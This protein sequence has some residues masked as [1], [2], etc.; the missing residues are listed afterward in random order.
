M[1]LKLSSITSITLNFFSGYHTV[2][3][4]SE[5]CQTSNMD[6]FGKTVNGFKPLTIFPKRST[7]DV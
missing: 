2:E 1:Y 3:E 6:R 7:L 4:Y 5:Y